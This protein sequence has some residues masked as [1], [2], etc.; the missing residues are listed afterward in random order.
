MHN[1]SSEDISFYD[2]LVDPAKTIPIKDKKGSEYCIKAIDIFYIECKESDKNQKDNRDIKIIHFCNRIDFYGRLLQ[3][4]EWYTKQPLCSIVEELGVNTFVQINKRTIVRTVL[5]QGRDSAWKNIQIIGINPNYLS[6]NRWHPKKISVGRK[7]KTSIETVL[8]IINLVEVR[9]ING[10]DV[11]DVLFINPVD[12][13]YIELSKYERVIHLNKPYYNNG[14]NCYEIIW[15]SG[16]KAAEIIKY[17]R[18][19]SIVQ[20]NRNTLINLNYIVGNLPQYQKVIQLTTD[21]K[22]FIKLDL[23]EK[24]YKKIL[25]E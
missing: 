6:R 25:V 13:V 20:S 7:Y 9:N 23:T 16:F 14:N 4:F 11:S 19:N 24:Y 18:Y 5:L 21:N 17:F 1:N 15:K 3:S 22:S 10:N 2:L 12:I 8:K